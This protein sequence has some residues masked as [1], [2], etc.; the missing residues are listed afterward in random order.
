MVGMGFVGWFGCLFISQDFFG[1][2]FGYDFYVQERCDDSFYVF[3]YGRQVQGEEYFKEQYGL[4]RGF[5]YVQDGFR[6]DDESQVCVR[7]IL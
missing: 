7:G 6:E 5:R 4:V 1:D 3:E 2:L